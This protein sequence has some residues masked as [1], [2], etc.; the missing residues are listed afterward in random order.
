[1]LL[2]LMLKHSRFLVRVFT[3]VHVLLYMTLIVVTAF[4]CYLRLCYFA[5]TVNLS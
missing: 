4:P 3:L 2:K 5:T 1:M